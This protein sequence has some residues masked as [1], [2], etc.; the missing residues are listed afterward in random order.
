MGKTVLSF[1]M[2]GGNGFDL[3]IGPYYNVVGPDGAADWTLRFA[4]NWIFP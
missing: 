3:M 4:I 2:G 1:D